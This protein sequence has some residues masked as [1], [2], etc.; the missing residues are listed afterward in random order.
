MLVS[1]LSSS[2]VLDGKRREL[3]Q[4]HRPGLK[5]QSK[6]YAFDRMR[7]VQPTQLLSTLGLLLGTG[8]ATNTTATATAMH[9]QTEA[10]ID[11][12]ADGEEKES[13]GKKRD[14]SKPKEEP[15]EAALRC[16]C[17]FPAVC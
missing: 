13:K 16:P 17:A 14:R 8:S 11:D 9:R 7:A 3:A 4:L 5:L 6:T 15:K 2:A 1:S 12:D 10:D